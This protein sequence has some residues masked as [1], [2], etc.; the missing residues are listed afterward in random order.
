MIDLS[1][2]LLHTGVRKTYHAAFNADVFSYQMGNYRITYK[3]PALFEIEGLSGDKIRIT[4]SLHVRLEIP[5][6][7]CLNP[8]DADLHIPFEQECYVGEECPADTE[9]PDFINDRKLDT[10]A[11]LFQEI[12]VN[13]PV[14]VLCKADCRGICI[15]CGKNLNTGDCG[16]D[17]F[18]PD[19]RMAAISD[20]FRN[21]KTTD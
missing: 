19:P 18:V 8:V 3:E 17:G 12:L 9:K 1:D 5:C 21:F 13:L 6:G 15:K 20:I 16:C 14:K 2:V 10:E 11:F 4:G 7:R